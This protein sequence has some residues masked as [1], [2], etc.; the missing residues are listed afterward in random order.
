MTGEVGRPEDVAEAYVWCMKDG[1]VTGQRIG[2]DGGAL[3][4]GA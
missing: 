2:S 3:L 1:F 4:K